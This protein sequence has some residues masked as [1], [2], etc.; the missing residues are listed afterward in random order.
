MMKYKLNWEATFSPLLSV[1]GGEIINVWDEIED[2]QLWDLHKNGDG[3][4][5]RGREGPADCNIV[6][7]IS[8]I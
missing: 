4:V 7:W 1:Y 5:Q 3:T 2:N 8:N 6:H